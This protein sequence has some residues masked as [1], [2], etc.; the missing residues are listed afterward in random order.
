M[1]NKRCPRCG[2]SYPP[3]YGSCPYCSE[4]SRRRRPPENLID[5]IVRILRQDGER[6]FLVCTAVFLAIALLGMILT[7]CSGGSEPKPVPDSDTQPPEA[8]DPLPP[9][10][11]LAVSNPTL[12][13]TVGEAAV[14]TVTG[15]EE[16]PVWT[17]SDEA[18]AS[19]ADGRVTANAAG[20][21]TITAAS[22]TER[23]V[24]VVTVKEKDPDVEVYLNRTDFTLRPQDIDFQMEVKVRETRK[25]YEG[26]V[27]WSIE[28]PSVAT[29]SETGLVVKVSKGTTKVTA[30]MGT[31]TLECIVRVS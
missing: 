20:T 24:C 10:D 16:P 19:V 26:S 21:A 30:T 18:V 13:L 1:S 23:A 2:R 17:S 31:K 29:I 7:R 25:P 11:P 9:K 3:S 6:I 22:G 4:G 28:D 14:L 12:A 8:E 27:I 5:R 15:G